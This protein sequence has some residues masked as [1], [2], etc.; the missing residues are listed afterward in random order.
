MESKQWT[1]EE[2]TKVCLF[3]SK[4]CPNRFLYGF[5][6]TKKTTTGI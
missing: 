2:E 4:T 3:I 1:N 5:Y 6:F